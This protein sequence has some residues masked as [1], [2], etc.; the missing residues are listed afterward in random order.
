MTI[1]KRKS[2]AILLFGIVGLL[3]VVRIVQA[4]SST[5]SSTAQQGISPEGTFLRGEEAIA[6]LL[7]IG[8]T[9]EEINQMR[10]KAQQ[11]IIRQV[12][13]QEGEKGTS[14]LLELGVTQEQ[15]DRAK[16][17]M[18]QENG[19]GITPAGVGADVEWMMCGGL[20]GAALF[21][22][23]IGPVTGFFTTSTNPVFGIFADVCPNAFCIYYHFENSSSYFFSHYVF[24]DWA[25]HIDAWCY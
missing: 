2:V 13:E 5:L 17:P 9:Q 8:Y 24:A 20:G 10:A 1:W 18:R 3:P 21:E 22:T 25:D 6:K 12:I 4:G 16:Q 14:K 15:I 19:E 7:E 23:L 11:S